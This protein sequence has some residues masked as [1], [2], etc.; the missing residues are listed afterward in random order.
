MWTV[1]K[2]KANKIAERSPYFRELLFFVSYTIVY[3][4]PDPLLERLQA[5]FLDPVYPPSLG[6]ED[7]L[8]LVEDVALREVT[9]GQ[10]QFRGTVLPGDIRK[11][12][13]RPVLQPGVRAE[14]LT[15]ETLPLFFQVDSKG[16]RS[17]QQMMPLSF[18]PVQLEIELPSPSFPVFQ[19]DGRNFTWANFSPS[20]TSPS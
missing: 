16:V 17:P 13:P 19:L 12:L 5:A 8:A 3:S 6:R 1:L 2:I 9:P 18:V 4:L 11:D 10:P 20:P 15:V 14:P 7:E